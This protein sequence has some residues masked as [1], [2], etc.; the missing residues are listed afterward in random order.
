MV[1]NFLQRNWPVLL[2]L[3]IGY[4]TLAIHLDNRPMLMWDESRNAVNAMEMAENGHPFVRYYQE[5][6]DVWET[7]PPMLTWFQAISMNIF[8]YNTFAARFPIMLFAFFT[9]L[10]IYFVMGRISRSQGS[11]LLAGIVLLTTAGYVGNHVA[12]TG[13]HDALLAFWMLLQLVFLFDAVENPQHRNRSMVFF[14]IS[15]IFAVLTKSIAGL[16]FLPGFLIWLI[17]VREFRN[18][19]LRPFT[20]I[21][22]LV[23]LFGVGIYYLI[24]EKLQP[25]YISS[26]FGDEIWNRFT[27]ANHNHDLHQES[28]FFYFKNLFAERFFPWMYFIPVSIWL[29]FNRGDSSEKKWLLM[30]LSVAFSTL[31]ILSFG[32]AAHWYDAITLP[33]LAM[34]VGMGLNHLSLSFSPGP[35]RRTRPAPSLFSLLFF[36]AILLPPLVGAFTRSLHN[37]EIWQDEKYGVAMDMAEKKVPSLDHYTVAHQGYNAVA[38]FYV[39]QRKYEGKTHP[40]LTDNFKELKRGDTLL[41]CQDWIVDSLLLKNHCDTLW[42]RDGCSV[43]VVRGRRISN[44]PIWSDSTVTIPLDSLNKLL[45]QYHP[46]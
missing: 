25:G 20:F 27:N 14:T 10:V 44:Q 36:L 21:L 28:I 1:L 33:L 4:F 46:Q 13:D 30:L 23:W 37:G 41:T 39:E 5:A 35:G 22:F 32:T 6:P 2:L 42:S 15:L 7:K 12:R 18:T 45:G 31:L 43:V 29:V 16:F 26:V 38:L 19:L 9:L 8:G 3:I 34:I 24:H 11:G 40:I 17:L